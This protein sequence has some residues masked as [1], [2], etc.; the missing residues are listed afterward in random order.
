MGL[1][2]WD[3]TLHLAGVARGSSWC[4]IL[5]V[6]FRVPLPHEAALLRIRHA[7]VQVELRRYWAALLEV[8]VPTVD[9]L[10]LFR[11]AAHDIAHED[12]YASVQFMAL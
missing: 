4:S 5:S 7:C 3:V 12:L 10:L 6:Q 1:G 2:Y 11:T 8:Q 9:M